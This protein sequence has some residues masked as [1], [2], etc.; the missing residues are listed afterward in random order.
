MSVQLIVY[1]QDLIT[2]TANVTTTS[3]GA[4]FI[5]DGENFYTLNTSTSVEGVNDGNVTGNG[6][7][8]L[9]ANPPNTPNVWYR[10]RNVSSDISPA[11]YLA[12]PTQASNNVTWTTSG[13]T[14]TPPLTPNNWSSI[15]QK[16]TGLTIGQTYLVTVKNNCAFADKSRAVLRVLYDYG[17]GWTEVT[18]SFEP[19]NGNYD[20]ITCGGSGPSSC[21]LNGNPILREFTAT[22]TEH[23]FYLAMSAHSASQTTAVITE[24]SVKEMDTTTNTSITSSSVDIQGQQILD[25]YEEES[26][27][28][29]LSVDDFKDVATKTQSYSK[30]FHLPATKKN[31]K[32]FGN[33]YDVTKTSD[34]YTFNQYKKTNIILKEDG[35]IIFKG[36]L[37]LIDI[38][39]KDDEISYNVNLYSESVSLMDVIKN[40]K[41]F[42]LY[43]QELDHTYNKT[44]I[45]AS[46]T[47]AL[48]LTNALPID[49]FA[50]N[51]GVAGATT[52]DV[53]KYP[54]VDWSGNINRNATS[55][56]VTSGATANN[57][58]LNKL[59]DGF[60]PFIKVKY[61]V[62]N[63]FSEAGFTYTSNFFDTTFFSKLY[64]D[65]NWGE[66]PNGSAPN[67][68]D[69]VRRKTAAIN[70]AIGQTYTNIPLSQA[71][72]GNTALW[73]N[74]DYKFT[75]DVNNL[76]V[77]GT[78]A[79]QLENTS[80][81]S[82][83]SA[84]MRICK[85][86]ANGSV[87]ETFEIEKVLI[88][89]LGSG[90]ISGSFQT[91]LNLGD[92][93]QLQARDF[94]ASADIYVSD[95]T[96]S[97]LNIDYNNNPVSVVA[98]LNTARGQLGQWEFLKGLI[99]MFNLITLQDKQDPDNLIIEPYN[100]IFTDT[101]DTLDW[102]HK[103]DISDIKLKPF[104]L[105]RKTVFQ[106]QEDEEDYPF[107][108]YK[109]ALGGYLYGSA[110]V[111][112]TA[113][114]LL[115]EEKEII[116]S[117]FGATIVKPLFDDIS[118]LYAPVIYGANEDSTEF[119]SIKNSPR[120]LFDTGVHTILNSYY[121]PAQNGI[122]DDNATT[123]S[124][125][126]HT[127][128]IPATSTD[129][130]LNFG[131]CQLIAIGISPLDNLYQTYYDQ[132]FSE[133]YSADVKTMTLK[134]MLTPEDIA[135]FNFYDKI[136][137]KNREYRVDKINYQPNELS[138]V[139][140]ILIT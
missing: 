72:G 23:Y 66:D 128:A 107:M 113:L 59:E 135:N 80:A 51:T 81:V 7:I 38:I 32:V 31:N 26:M 57:P 109:Q 49:S 62:D 93:I 114:D 99:T 108:V 6:Y 22:H 94:N 87:V 74:T 15:Y 88:A 9:Q 96:Q 75:S 136:F 137:I 53:L 95:T 83:W 58:S 117:P 123:Y 13:N 10:Y 103:V 119:G 24:I 61:L 25:L 100:D 131:A 21:F 50:N 11:S 73:D 63:I 1:P 124:L 55:A 68:N 64:M 56:H 36:F 118:D 47:G 104:D 16:M 77:T 111:D 134:V 3:I 8:D 82:T 35:F 122:A 65:F 43:L 121:I 138:T 17:G 14:T 28:L 44:S 54:L 48:P 140:F 2:T 67:R 116:A 89:T 76:Q 37:R 112:F 133:L 85:F 41:M 78:Y 91:V 126:S 129:T 101:V 102:T 79:I 30:A 20:D 5:V 34:A 110:T 29:T 46:Q 115:E 120:I 86:N 125:F 45:Q 33:I 127:S 39:D 71:D 4:E 42:H 106:Y 92:Y 27:P 69:Y 12:Y 40:R 70:T 19:P 52:T 60:R 105:H 132:Y 90:A 98:L 84:E 130:D 18:G 139:D 97:Y